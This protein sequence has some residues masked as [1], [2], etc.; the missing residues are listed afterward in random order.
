MQ[1]PSLA[2][3]GAGTVGRALAHRWRELHPTAPLRLTV[4]TPESARSLAALGFEVEPFD[5]T[6]DA[7]R[8]SEVIAGCRA[9]VFCVAAG[10]GGDYGGV[11]GDGTARAAEVVRVEGAH[12]LYTSSTGVYA[13]RDGGWVDEHASL[14]RQDERTRALVRAEENVRGV[15]G[16]VLR[17]AGIIA[18]AWG[19][20]RTASRWSGAEREDGEGWL[21]LAPLDLIV[22]ALR[23][24]LEGNWRGVV[25][26]SSAAP[27]LRRDFYDAVLAHAGLPPVR[28]RPAPPDAPRGRRVR[29]DRLREELGVEPAPFNVRA[30]LE[31]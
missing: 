27:L 4:R 23:A 19:P 26:V 1:A 16:T 17:L 21:N 31:G 18:P 5:V 24:A 15:D 3:V 29:V 2:I 30:F 13:E 11:Y 14:A 6:A 7:S 25:N 22:S 9:V 10:R 12:L 8:W 28:W 20:H